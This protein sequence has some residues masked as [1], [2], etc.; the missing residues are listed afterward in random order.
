[1]QT[2]HIPILIRLRALAVLGTLVGYRLLIELLWR[3]VFC[4]RWRGSICLLAGQYLFLGNLLLDWTVLDSLFLL[5]KSILILI[6]LNG[7]TISHT[8]I[9]LNRLRCS[10]NLAFRNFSPFG[11]VIFLLGVNH[12]DL[13]SLLDSPEQDHIIRLLDRLDCVSLIWLKHLAIVLILGALIVKLSLVILELHC[14][15]LLL[16]LV[17][18]VLCTIVASCVRLPHL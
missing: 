8:T 1:M 15:L 4:H 6:V 5:A 14:I 17:G 13:A 12:G 7:S 2:A 16:L 10:V 9:L 3:C 18:L 11:Q